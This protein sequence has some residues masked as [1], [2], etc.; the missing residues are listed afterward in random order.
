V[1]E[2]RRNATSEYVTG[3]IALFAG[4]KKSART[5]DLYRLLDHLFKTHRAATGSLVQIV[6]FTIRVRV[7]VHLL[8]LRSRT[9]ITRVRF[10]RRNARVRDPQS[11]GP[12]PSKSLLCPTRG[13]PGHVKRFTESVH[14]TCTQPG[15]IE[16]LFYVDD[17]DPELARYEIGVEALRRR[18]PDFR[19]IELIVGPAMSV[20]RSWNVLAERCDGDL[21]MM[22]NDD[23]LYVDYGWDVEL[24]RHAR[25]VSDGIYAF[26]FDGGQYEPGGADF[27][28]VSRRWYE[29]LGYF[30]PGI[31]EFWF[32][33]RWIFDVAARLD[34]VRR[35]PHVYVA[36]LHFNEYSAV[37]DETYRRHRL[38]TDRSAR[39]TDLY[40]ST[41]AEREAAAEALRPLMTEYWMQR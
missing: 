20:S 3:L 31:F 16:L 24:E 33:E 18:L 23:Q 30:T 22:A 41:S 15:R 1:T 35:V 8:A 12:L 39:D 2:P 37:L 34:R 13:R 11:D 4:H 21:L 29:A 17:D 40:E 36:H 32:N 7:L 27:P 38:N 5:A 25:R 28:I 9:K 10:Q 14:R 19:R 6:N 26:F